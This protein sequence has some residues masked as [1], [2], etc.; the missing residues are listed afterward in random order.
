[1]VSELLYV[2]WAA[3]ALVIV[4]APLV[5]GLDRWWVF[6]LLG[7]VVG[8]VMAISLGTL[9][10]AAATSV[11]LLAFLVPVEAI[12]VGYCRNPAALN[13]TV[14]GLWLAFVAWVVR[15]LPFSADT[16]R[17]AA[18][19]LPVMFL[20]LLLTIVAYQKAGAGAIARGRVTIELTG[21]LIFVAAAFAYPARDVALYLVVA[22][23]VLGF[24]GMWGFLLATH[25]PRTSVGAGSAPAPG[26]EV[27]TGPGPAVPTAPGRQYCPT[28]GS[29]NE[30]D[31][32]FCRKCGRGLTGGRPKPA[33]AA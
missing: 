32:A 27:P 11:F 2:G 29:D 24:T 20:F 18:F 13:L 17:L 16:L 9:S 6:P 3:A 33:A 15:A 14:A 4:G 28:C 10:P 8:S 26:E 30:G 19:V 12:L 7:V 1:M 31:S 22:G 25:L 23:A 21:V 5:A